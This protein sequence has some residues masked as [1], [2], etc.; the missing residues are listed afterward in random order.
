MTNKIRLK[1]NQTVRF[2]NGRELK[3]VSWIG[4]GGQGIVYKGVDEAT[5]EEFAVKTSMAQEMVYKQLV[6]NIE[7]GSPS[8]AFTWP[9]FISERKD[10][11]FCYAMPLVTS[12][13]KKFGKFMM[14]KARFK[15]MDA[16]INAAIN[17]VSAFKLLHNS[18][19]SY[20]DINEENIFFDP[21]NGD[22]MICDIENV[23]GQGYHSGIIGKTRYM[24]P[25]IV[26][27]E[28]MPDKTTD[29]YSLALILF[30]LLIGDHPLEGARTNVPCL[31][32]K[33]DRRFNGE[34][35]LFI[36]DKEND[37][38]RPMEGIQA[39][40]IT[41]WGCYPAYIRNAF[42]R[43][44]SQESLLHRSGRLQEQ[45]WLHLLMR[46]KS[47]IVRC[48]FC[49][50]EMFMD[51]HKI[52]RCT[53]CNSSSMA[54]GYLKFKKRFNIDIE[55]P[56]FAGARLFGYHLFED[57]SSTQNVCAIVLEKNGKIGLRNNSD[58]EWVVTSADGKKAV[59]KRPG[60]TSVLGVG[61]NI[62]FSNGNIAK[63]YNL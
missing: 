34:Q 6:R 11:T 53:E 55:V 23:M 61:F 15:N 27:G 20:Q 62:D 9:L 18:G 48:P 37:A 22:V 33:Y 35:P 36:F 59:R 51:C 40:A 63:I 17:L 30:M 56:I 44:F 57:S 31:T 3:I 10:D 38:N 1:K 52:S 24:A 12:R 54:S 19:F 2:L 8:P 14:A 28:A 58:V 4:E 7:S 49:Q 47:S 26:R 21:N 41:L 13:Y 46:L 42:E 43:S 32:N 25:E 16:M 45:E 5:G 39:N 29:A 60:E 50:E